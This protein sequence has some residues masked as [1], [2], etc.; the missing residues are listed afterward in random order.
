MTNRPVA[1]PKILIVDDVPAN[2][3]VLAKQLVD[4]YELLAATSGDEDT[5]R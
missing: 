5:Y 4:K 2:I 3:Q 1:M